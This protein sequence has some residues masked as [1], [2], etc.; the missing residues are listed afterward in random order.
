MT[1]ANETRV[2]NDSTANTLEA[3]CIEGYEYAFEE[4]VQDIVCTETG[5]DT[6]TIQPCRIGEYA[7]LIPWIRL[8]QSI[9]T[10]ISYPY[11]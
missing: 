10:H 1:V 5:Y 8:V 6:S 7:C 9:K 4:T 2:Y 11:L 3:E